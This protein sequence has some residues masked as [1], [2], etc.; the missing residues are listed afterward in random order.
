MVSVVK[1]KKEY[2]NIILFLQNKEQEVELL[3]DEK[4]SLRKKSQFFIILNGDLFLRDSE[5][6][7]KR[8]F[9]ED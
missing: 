8:V 2:D 4:K 5:N 1:N 6:L 9:C 3:K 7:H